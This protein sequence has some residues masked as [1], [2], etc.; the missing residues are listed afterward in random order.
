MKGASHMIHGIT[1]LDG[2]GG[3][4]LWD[5]AEEKV[6]VWRY[7][8]ENP[9][10]VS[11]LHR[12]YIEAGAEIIL[13]NTFGANGEM[14][15]HSPYTV[16]EVVSAGVRLAREAA[17]GKAKVALSIG[18]LT[19]LLEPYGDIEEEEA[20]AL[21]AEQISAGMDEHPDLIYFETFIDLSM[22]V[23]AV[24][25]AVKYSI[26]VFCTMSFEKVG[27]TI[28][29]NSVKDMIEALEP[30]G[31]AAVG[32]N[33]SLGPDTALPVMKMFRDETNLPLIFK[34][35][36]GMSVIDESGQAVGA[37]YDAEVFAGDVSPAAGMGVSYIGG[38]CGSTPH[39]IE[40]LR[41]RLESMNQNA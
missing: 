9:K 39:Y 24:K 27:K 22:L 29:G 16:R 34:P 35:N 21:Y 5:K 19:G 6:P 23:I 25:E 13:A 38:C 3:T 2:A 36:A 37:E 12:E 8:I 26:P 28:M 1:L 33:C 11:E 30:L 14:V 17:E 10:I 15:K 20:Q 7:N 40:V 41:G 31:V 18:P 4:C 32:L